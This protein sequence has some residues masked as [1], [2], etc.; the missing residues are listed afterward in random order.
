MRK[1]ILLVAGIFF[2]GMIFTTQA[3]ILDNW[4][5]SQIITNS[6]ALDSI[7]AGNGCYVVTA[8]FFDAGEI[9]SSPDGINWTLSYS[10]DSSWGLNLH[11]VNGRFV[12]VGGGYGTAAV[13]TNGTNW[14]IS[15]LPGAEFINNYGHGDITYAN[16]L[17]V[18]VGDSN[19]VGCIFTSSD[20][21]NWTASTSTTAFGGH[22]SSVV[23][24]RT[25]FVAIG[26]NDQKVYTS[27]TGTSWI[28]H[29]IPGGSQISFGTY[30][31]FIVPL[32]SQTNLYSDD[33]IF[34]AESSTGLTNE[35]S[36]VVVAGNMFYGRAGSYLATSTNGM[37]WV[38]YS[39]PLPG[40]TDPYETLATDGSQI[41]TIDYML[42][43]TSPYDT[44]NGYVYLSGPLVD[45]RL[46]GS[47]H[48]QVY[49]SGLVD[50]SYQIQ[51]ANTLSGSNNWSTNLTIQLANTLY[52]WTD[53]VATNSARFYRG[54]LLP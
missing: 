13:S 15:S 16:G 39:P 49:L 28:T 35:L 45:I 32:N 8:E 1:I 33:G 7:A 30:G 14:T 34:W 24:G 53:Y 29:P 47:A 10:D 9:F 41:A 11:Y 38:Q 17:Y 18:Q 37:S 21:S 54:V 23:C 4:T 12:G 51:S 43:S 6:Y 19:G 48:T 26:N 50:R 20:G 44:Y 22:I 36:N 2:L 25:G 3:D 42:Q 27:T 52:V 5:T 40:A 31:Y 46:A